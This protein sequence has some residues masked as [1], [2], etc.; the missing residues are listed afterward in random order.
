MIFAQYSWPSVT[1]NMFIF[2]S[3]IKR[4][5]WLMFVDA[6]LM[7]N[8]VSCGILKEQAVYPVSSWISGLD[9]QL[10]LVLL[11]NTLCIWRVGAGGITLFPHSVA[12]FFYFLFMHFFM[13]YSLQVIN[14]LKPDIRPGTP[15]VYKYVRIG[16]KHNIRF[17][18]ILYVGGRVDQFH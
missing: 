13:L 1:L 18:P 16:G 14:F 6:C 2:K 3:T 17:I 15:T 8:K 7:H 5:I 4:S 12:L 10:A 9:I 11:W